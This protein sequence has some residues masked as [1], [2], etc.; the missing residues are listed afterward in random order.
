MLAYV[1]DHFPARLSDFLKSLLVFCW[2]SDDDFMLSY[3]YKK[4][5][6]NYIP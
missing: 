3:D 1:G 2:H 6:S 4:K 5:R